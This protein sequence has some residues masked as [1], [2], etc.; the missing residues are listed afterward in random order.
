[1]YPKVEYDRW[2]AVGRV[3]KE[4]N[5]VQVYRFKNRTLYLFT[6]CP[7]NTLYWVYAEYS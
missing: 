4:V 3:E 2:D 5:Q 1:M 6:G 7:Y